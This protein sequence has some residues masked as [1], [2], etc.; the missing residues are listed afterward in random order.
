MHHD[1]LWRIL[2]ETG[3]SDYLTCLLRN[4]EATVK[5]RHGIMDWFQTGKGVR[6]GCILSSL[7]LLNLHA[8]YI[9]QNARLDE[10]QARIKMQLTPPLWQKVKK[11]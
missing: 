1:N 3:I 8:E 2:K 7:C 6:Q 9:I 4:Q 11:N 10:A 5:T